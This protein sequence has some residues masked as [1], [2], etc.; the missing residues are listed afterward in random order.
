MKTPKRPDGQIQKNTLKQE[1]GQAASKNITQQITEYWQDYIYN[2]CD[3]IY[4]EEL[5]EDLKSFDPSKTEKNDATMASGYGLIAVK[6]PTKTVAE[7]VKVSV[8]FP[9]YNNRGSMSKRIADV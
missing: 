2:H 6:R 7:K 1:I 9:Q 4:F 5:L 8:L 3:K